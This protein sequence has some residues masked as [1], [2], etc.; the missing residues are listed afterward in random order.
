MHPTYLL[1]GLAAVIPAALA[2]E[3]RAD[4]VPSACTTI[5]QP[6][7]DLTNTCDID[8][9]ETDNDDDKRRKLRL[10]ESNESDEEAIEA[11]C[12]CT[13]TSFDIAAVMALCASCM[14]QNSQSTEDVDKIM[15]QCS[16]T[17]TSYVAS[18][19]AIVSGIQVEATK[20]ATTGA[21]ESTSTSGA[22][23]STDS[24]TGGAGKMAVSIIAAAG[25]GLIFM[26]QL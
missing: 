7:V 24:A 12:I 17:S 8:P 18:A 9:N 15:S 25:A 3:L 26:L 21:S 20:P 4:D 13:N 22:S 11:N 19:T 6:I 16:F 23:S 1:A 10:R 5:C 2:E 14:S